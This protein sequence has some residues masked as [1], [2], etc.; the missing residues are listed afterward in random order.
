ME[1]RR[2][3]ETEAERKAFKETARAIQALDEGGVTHPISPVNV[4]PISDVISLQHRSTELR[5]ITASQFMIKKFR[6]VQNTR[7]GKW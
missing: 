1:L 2:L 6:P 5:S 7:K 4:A 3:L